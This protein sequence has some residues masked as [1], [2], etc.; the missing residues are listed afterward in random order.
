[1]KTDMYTKAV[2]TVIAVALV[3]IGLGGPHVMPAAHAQSDQHVYIAGWVD[4]MRDGT[5][6]VVKLDER[7]LPVRTP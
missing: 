1:M 2:L 3:W 6:Y 4:H 7:G 5:P